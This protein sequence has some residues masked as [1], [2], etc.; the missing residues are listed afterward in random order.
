MVMLLMKVLLV[1]FRLVMCRCW[2]IILMV[3]CCCDMDGFFKCSLYVC[4]LLM[5]RCVGC[6]VFML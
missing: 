5:S 2:E 4:D 3:M 1:E 6:V